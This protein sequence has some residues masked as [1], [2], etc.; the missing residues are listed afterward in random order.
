MRV[1]RREVALSHPDKSLFTA[2]VISELDLAR[3]A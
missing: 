3:T 1:G 2:P